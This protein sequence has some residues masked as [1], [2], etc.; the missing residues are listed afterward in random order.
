MPLQT[1]QHLSTNEL[2]NDRNQYQNIDNVRSVLSPSP[3]VPIRRVSFTSV[4]EKLTSQRRRYIYSGMALLMCLITF[5]IQTETAGYLAT[6]L[7]YKK[8][9]FML[10]ITHSSWT[11]LWPIQ[12][13]VLRL[14]KWNLP[15]N[16]FW[17]LHLD[18]VLTTAEMILDKNTA[19][20]RPRHHH[21]HR[22]PRTIPGTSGNVYSALL[23][24]FKIFKLCV[25]LFTALTVAGSSWYIAINLTTTSDI[26]AIYNSSAFFA[27]AFSVPLLHEAFR[28]DKAVSVIIAML[29]VLIVAYGGGTDSNDIDSSKYPH[30]LIGN[31]VI[32]IG[33]VLY[34]LYEVL[35]KKLACPP[36]TISPRRQA[37]FA[38]VV[39]SGIGLATFLI[40]WILLPILHY[41]KLEEFELPTG[42]IL[43]LLITSVLS[44][45]LFSGGMLV[46][47]SLTSPVLSS[48]ASLLTIF[49]VAIVDWAL[50]GV[51]VTG[52]GAFGCVLIVI[53]FLL[54]S[55]ATWQEL[56][57]EDDGLL[58]SEYDEEA[59]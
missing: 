22:H 38:N 17:R 54:L 8:P 27:Y 34:G 47:M 28:W 3:S 56:S 31:F 39:G 21:H 51:P 53:A 24:L 52:A 2:S 4:D 11:F 50:F 43:G 59:F 19:D 40:L 58:E 9:I 49:L 10:Y 55:Y 33:A 18:N 32:G 12:I 42:K 36:S 44:N 29:G 25:Y 1:Y 6:T 30:R 14:R 45:M 35:Y 41:T 16:K 23:P 46:L 13:G 26:T 20:H 37:V 48:V 5:V 57:E 7:K 15:F